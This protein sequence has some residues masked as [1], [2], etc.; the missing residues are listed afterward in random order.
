MRHRISTDENCEAVAAF[1][2]SLYDRGRTEATIT[3]YRKALR[4]FAD[5]YRKQLGKPGPYL[6]RLQETDLQA[7]VEHLRRGRPLKVSSVNV[8]PVSTQIKSL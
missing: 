7:F 1:E 6:A 5:F 2:Q 3:T 8:S 4:V